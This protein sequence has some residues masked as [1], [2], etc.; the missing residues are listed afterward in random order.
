MRL[1]DPVTPSS[2]IECF[3]ENIRCPLLQQVS[4]IS[5]EG[6]HAIVDHRQVLPIAT[7]ERLHALG[8]PVPAQA[9]STSDD[10]PTDY[11]LSFLLQ[12]LVVAVSG[13]PVNESLCAACPKCANLSSISE[14]ISVVAGAVP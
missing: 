1:T 9:H 7:I 13:R 8:T 6:P 4:L 10:V 5:C 14:P 2:V 3:A 12:S 11:R